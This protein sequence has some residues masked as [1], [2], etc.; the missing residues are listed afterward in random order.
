MKIALIADIHG[1]V[2]ALDAVLQDAEKAQPDLYLC[3][4]DVVD[5]P[6]PSGSIERVVALPNHQ[7]ILGNTDR[8]IMQQE[9]PPELT[10][11]AVLESPQTLPKFQQ[12]TASFAWSRGHLC[13]TGWYETLFD[14]PI[15]WRAIL[16]SGQTLLAVHASPG[17]SDGPGIA[18]YT[19]DEQLDQLLRGCTE[20]IVCVGH[21]HL[22]FVRHFE[23]K[24]IINPG[25]VGNPLVDDQN[26]CYAILSA[27]QDGVTVDLR[28]VPY[29]NAGFIA[30]VRK[31]HHPAASYIVDHHLGRKTVEGQKITVA[32]RW[33]L[34]EERNRSLQ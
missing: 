33:H 3:L 25:S 32:A 16:P 31:S 14:W 1:N 7:C 23:E 2:P 24:L 22:P 34:I 21:T 15:E 26:A 12:A 9:E 11:A 29:D 28:Q 5:G 18:P 27:D 17:L 19:T 8:Y 13:A 30:M 10:V 4:G 6:D 20:S